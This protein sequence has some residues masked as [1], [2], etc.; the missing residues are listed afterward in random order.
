MTKVG[1]VVALTN[2]V[3]RHFIMCFQITLSILLVINLYKSSIWL[4]H[5][6]NALRF[7]MKVESSLLHLTVLLLP[8]HSSINHYSLL[9]T[10]YHLLSLLTY[11]YIYSLSLLLPPS[12]LLLFSLF[13]IIRHMPNPSVPITNSL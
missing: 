11:S 9:I 8:F 3:G 1:E 6:F 12:I 13:N 10:H 2:F 7:P 4:K 5:L